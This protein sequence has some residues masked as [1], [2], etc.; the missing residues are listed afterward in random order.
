MMSTGFDATRKMVSG[1]AAI[2]AGTISAK[3]SAVA[4]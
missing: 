3:I 2:A 1:A 4:R